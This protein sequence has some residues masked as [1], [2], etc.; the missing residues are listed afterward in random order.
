MNTARGGT[1]FGPHDS[2]SV[3]ACNVWLHCGT[4]RRAWRDEYMHMHSSMADDFQNML[5]VSSA[6]GKMEKRSED[7]WF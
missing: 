3:K 2:G 1:D 7:T 4:D 5:F 6:C